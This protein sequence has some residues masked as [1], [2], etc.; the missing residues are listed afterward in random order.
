MKKRQLVGLFIA[1]ALLTVGLHAQELFLPPAGDDFF[2]ATRAKFRVQ[3]TPL[4][5]SKGI[6]TSNDL[7]VDAAARRQSNEGTQTAGE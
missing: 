2:P 6:V 1:F 3:F 4:L 7:E 5:L